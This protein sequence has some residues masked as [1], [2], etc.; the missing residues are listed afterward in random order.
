MRSVDSH[1]ATLFVIRVQKMD[2][3]GEYDMPDV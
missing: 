2:S 3:K 1:V